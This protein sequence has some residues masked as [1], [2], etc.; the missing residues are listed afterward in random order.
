[1]RKVFLLTLIILLSISSCK[2]KDSSYSL[3][4]SINNNGTVN[5]ES[6][7][8]PEGETI[9]LE[10]TPESG[11]RFI[12]WDGED[13]ESPTD[14]NP[15]TIFMDSNKSIIANFVNID[16][17]DYSGMGFWADEIYSSIDWDLENNFRSIVEAFVKDGERH[18]VDVSHVLENDLKFEL[19]EE[20][21][22]AKANAPG[23]C[24]KNR[25]SINYVS[26]TYLAEIESLKKGTYG[27]SNGIRYDGDVPSIFKTMW[28]EF[29]H[30]ILNLGHTCGDGFI[31]NGSGGCEPGIVTSGGPQ[32]Y[33]SWFASS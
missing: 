32:S 25:V 12:G 16:D 22:G 1:M 30:D 9:S 26:S 15:I 4:I 28:H 10:A 3:T 8:Y 24:W 29:G 17:P 21:P 5:Y 18:G 2:K 11:Y 13:L 6:G 20:I 23:T 33:Y 7:K 19:V 31:M 27:Y 14:E